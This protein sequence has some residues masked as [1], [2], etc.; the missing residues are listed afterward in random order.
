MSRAPDAFTS[1]E[2]RR[3]L[4][5]FTLPEVGVAGQRRLREARVLL[6]GVGGLGSPAALYLVAAGV[7]HL[8]L[9]DPDVVDLT[10]LQRQ[11]LY[12]TPDLGRPKVDVARETLLALNPHLDIATHHARFGADNAAALL[13]DY[14]L[15][16]D[17]ADNFPTR[18]LVNDACVLAGKP[19]VHGSIYRFE[20][21]VSLFAAPGGPCYRCLYP[22]PPPPGVVPDCA[23]AGVLGVLPGL[24]GAIMATE[25][26]K[27]I[28]GLGD[29]LAGRLLLIDARAT[30]FRELRVTRDP[31]CPLCGPHATIHTL[32]ELRN[33]C[34]TT[35]EPPMNLAALT[36]AELKQERDA[37]RPLVLLDV[38]EAF[39][40]DI[41]RLDP[42]VHIPLGELPARIGELDPASDIVCLC[43]SGGRSARAVQ[44][45]AQRGFPRVRN[46]T[47]GILGWSDDVDPS[48]PKY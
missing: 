3:Y 47:R 14:D 5:H 11:V 21:Q 30:K 26:I 17:G 28:L 27:Y 37:N 48:L 44:Y 25:A 15:V 33:T 32:E 12:R 31:A 42:C 10:N 38:R 19:N 40:L 39:E 7:G 24:V 4:R 2:Q 34:A 35:P 8:G 6:V 41:A 9:I 16:L 36:P 18:Y 20:G 1:D 22:E 13:A 45:L 29:S 46:L 43:R 23:S